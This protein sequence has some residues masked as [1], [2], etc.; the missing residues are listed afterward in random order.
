MA[1]KVILI[2]II[3]KIDDHIIIIGFNNSS[4]NTTYNSQSPYNQNNSFSAISNPNRHSQKSTNM[5]SQTFQ[6]QSITH[7]QNNTNKKSQKNSFDI[8]QLNNLFN[9]IN[10]NQ[11]NNNIDNYSNNDDESINLLLN[12][13]YGKS[14]S[15]SSCGDYTNFSNKDNS[16]ESINNNVDFS[17]ILSSFLHG[18][19]NS[20]NSSQELNMPDIETIMK[21]KKIFDRLNSKDNNPIVNLLYAVKPFMQ[22]SKKSIIDQLAKFMTISSALQDF[23]SFL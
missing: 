12:D 7:Q 10:S 2:A 23:N 1:I 17:S 21:F 8:N 18:N 6:N 19:S 22:D 3:I 9:A 5:K 14:D 13:V 20:A 15:S 4:Q 16:N 11:L